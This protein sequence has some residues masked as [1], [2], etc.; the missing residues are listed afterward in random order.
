MGR[1]ILML[2]ATALILCTVDVSA[3][4]GSRAVDNDEGGP[5]FVISNAL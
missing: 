4:G 3:G 2:A 1:L 5:T